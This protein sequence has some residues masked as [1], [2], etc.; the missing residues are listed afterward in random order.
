MKKL[1]PFV[2][3]TVVFLI[4]FAPVASFVF[5][6]KNDFFLGYFP[7]KFLLSETLRSG[8]WPLWN[9]Y[10]SFGLPFYADM[11]GAYWNPLTWIIAL[12]TGYSAY[13]LTLELLLYV[14]LGGIGMYKLAQL[15]SDNIYICLTTSLAFLCNGFVIGH[16]QH[17]NWI[18][19]SAFLPWCIWGILRINKA[20]TIRNYIY[21]LFAFFFLITASHP[22]MIIGAIYFFTALVLFLLYQRYNCRENGAFISGLKRYGFF[23]V[24]LCIVSSGLIASYTDILPYFARNTKVDLTLS[25]SENTNIQS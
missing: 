9:P 23:I 25:L 7:P 18:S 2:F 3:I 12:T 1:F 17:L 14:L 20:A 22:G 16:L 4:A 21:T 10:I 5:A 19:C 8:Q 13:T 24:L 6:L 15:F 11:N